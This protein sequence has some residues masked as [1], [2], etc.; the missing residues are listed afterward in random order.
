MYIYQGL[1]NTI[2]YY[3]INYPPDFCQLNG[4]NMSWNSFYLFLKNIYPAGCPIHSSACF[5]FYYL[6]FLF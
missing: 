3:S 1:T 6:L 4:S 5:I 2:V